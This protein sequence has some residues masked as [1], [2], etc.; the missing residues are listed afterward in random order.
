MKKNLIIILGITLLMT[1]LIFSSVIAALPGTGWWTSFSVQNIDDSNPDEDGSISMTAYPKVGEPYSGGPFPVSTFSALIYHPGKTG[2]SNYINFAGGL[3]IGFQG[4]VVLS[5]NVKSAAAAEIA[6]YNSGSVGGGGTASGQYQAMGLDIADTM[7]RVPTVKHNY[8]NQ[9]TT[10]Y[11]QAA[12]SDTEVKV[13]YRM[14]NGEDYHQEITIPTNRMFVFDPANTLPGP[15]PS[16]NCGTNPNTSQCFGAATIESLSGGK[17]AATYV[18]HPHSGSPAPFILSTRAQ[19][20]ADESSKLFGAS[21]KNTY[22]TGSGTGITGDTIMNVGDAPALVRISLTVTNKGNNAPSW[23]K[24]G[25]TFT[26]TAVINPGK[27]IVFSQWDNNLGGMPPGTFAAVQYE[28]INGSKNGISYSAQPL[29]GASNDAKDQPRLIGGK[30]KTV[31]KLFADSTATET[32][33]VPIIKEYF[34][35]ITGALTVQNVSSTAA[36]IYFEYYEIGSDNSPRVFRTKNLINPGQAINNYAISRNNGLFET[37]GSW[38]FSS[39]A[40]KQ[41][42]VRVYSDPAVDIICLVSENSPEGRFDIRNY[43]GF[44]ID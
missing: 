20:S 43:E 38:D 37:V 21:V 35:G 13:T 12:E 7:L 8:R 19:T 32:V 44:N 31:Y 4:S 22:T 10:I 26:D 39:L 41:F 5:S 14:N 23:V 1:L 29:V 30:G 40:G 24:I 6:N 42:S 16:T 25:D 33:A 3:P 28:S 18:E 36:R 15:I 9:T 11:V 27:S 2:L 34:E 17:I